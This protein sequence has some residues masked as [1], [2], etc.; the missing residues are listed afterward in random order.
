MS[1]II[2][3]INFL[4][5]IEENKE[6]L[7]P[8]VNNKV[9]YK[10]TE[11]IIMVVGGPNSRKDYHYNE[12]EEFFYQIKGDIIVK[13]QEDGKAKELPIRE[14]EIFLLPPKIPHNPIRLKDTI[15]LV[16][17]RK[18]RPNEKDGLLWFC[19]HCNN[20]LYEEYFTLTDI[21]TQFQK[22]F[23]KFYTSVELRTC[24]KCSNILEPPPIIA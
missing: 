12:S 2:P 23:E 19:E 18:R 5:W 9:V 15:G 4:K 11:F 6:F 24:K 8:P 16:I 7:K 14:G 17:E 20:Q 10:D 21:T 3:P 22:V 1:V 13:I